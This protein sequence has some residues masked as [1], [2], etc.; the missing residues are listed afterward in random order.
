MNEPRQLPVVYIVDPSMATTGALVAARRMT[1][2]LEAA[3]VA[4]CVLVVSSKANLPQGS[5]AGFSGYERIAMVPLSKNPVAMLGYL[6]ALVMGTLKLRRMMEEDAASC[7]VLNDFYLLHGALLRCMLFPGRIVGMVRCDPYRFMGPLGVPL[8]RLLRL[9][10]TRVVAVSQCVR[11]WMGSVKADALLYEYADARVRDMPANKR[12]VFV[13]NYIRGKGQDMALRAF[14]RVVKQVPEATLAFYGGDMGLAK[15]HA[16]YKELRLLA[17]ELNI[18]SN[19]LFGQHVSDVNDVLAP[20]LAALNFSECE[21]FSMTVLEASAAAVP[22][23]ATN[24]GGPAEIILDGETGYLVHVGDEAAAAERM[25]EL[26]RSPE[27]AFAM[28]K[29]AAAHVGTKFHRATY[30]KQLSEILGL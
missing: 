6:P 13:G 28:G 29:A 3:E 21:S 4:R 18:A 2:A 23:I 22:V 15:N 5:N 10:S 16:Y 9:T 12:F 17:S 25:L 7:L 26:A 8:L 30:M 24:S 20:A 1:Q 11:E 14:A 19:V 27:K